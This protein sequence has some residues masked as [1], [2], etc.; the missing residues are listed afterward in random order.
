MLPNYLVSTKYDGNQIWIVKKD[1][2]FFTSDW[3]EFTIPH[4][5]QSIQFNNR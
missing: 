2:S 1:G 4:L 5:V 3:K